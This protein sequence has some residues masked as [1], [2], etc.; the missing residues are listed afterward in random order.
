MSSVF[1]E[2]LEILFFLPLIKS[3]NA[4]SSQ[5]NITNLNQ[6]AQYTDCF[7][8]TMASS[9][10]YLCNWNPNEQTC[11]T[12]YRAKNNNIDLQ[13][14]YLKCSDQNSLT[15]IDNYCEPIKISEN[16]NKFEI[17]LKYAPKNLLCI[18]ESSKILSN[19]YLFHVKITKNNNNISI[20]LLYTY[21]LYKR[22][23]LVKGN[24]YEL[25][26]SGMKKVKFFIYFPKSFTNKNL[27]IFTI[28]FDY[29][30]PQKSSLS[31]VVFNIFL[32][33][34]F[35][36][37]IIFCFCFIMTYWK[38]KNQRIIKTNSN[39]SLNINCV[40]RFS[41]E[42]IQ[43]SILY[44]EKYNKYNSQCSICLEDFTIH[45][46]VHI[47]K[48]N[49]IFHN[50]CLK[51]WIEKKKTNKIEFFCPICHIKPFDGQKSVIENQMKI[52]IK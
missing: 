48:C 41:D 1:L 11:T 10:N 52:N 4:N 13:D 5:S 47:F 43:N 40:T 3:Q 24:N 46:H 37:L 31:R 18:Y 29:I 26:M 44:S 20:G 34:G 28:N 50:K 32:F 30:K 25:H 42:I 39:S 27:N 17:T 16:E 14:L 51:E 33:F 45:S 6:C 7:N 2:I 9:S 19:D 22:F 15:L 12:F 38:L 49:H 23:E 36:F 8:C 35:I 21:W